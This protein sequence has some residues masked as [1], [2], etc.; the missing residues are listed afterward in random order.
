MGLQYRR[1]GIFSSLVRRARPQQL[2]T[3]KSGPGWCTNRG[4][5]RGPE[6]A[7]GGWGGAFA[8]DEKPCQ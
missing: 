5:A 3:R 8:P 4:L 2:A 1:R 7:S 6:G